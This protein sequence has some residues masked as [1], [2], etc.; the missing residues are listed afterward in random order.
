MALTGETGALDAPTIPLVMGDLRDLAPPIRSPMIG[1]VD[2]RHSAPIGWKCR[3][4]ELLIDA[5]SRSSLLLPWCVR[6]FS[7]SSSSFTS[8]K[9][10]KSSSPSV[11]SYIFPSWWMWKPPTTSIK[12][13]QKNWITFRRAFRRGSSWSWSSSIR[14][15]N[16]KSSIKNSI[17]I[18][19]NNK[20]MPKCEY[21]YW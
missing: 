5:D 21:I 16:Y 6:P 15:S 4:W 9:E 14:K 11:T 13:Q 10:K 7:S 2:W 12:Q 18:K 3:S 20:N 17:I 8:L 1:S 19:R